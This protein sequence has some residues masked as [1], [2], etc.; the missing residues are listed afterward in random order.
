MRGPRGFL[1]A[2][3][4]GLVLVLAAIGSVNLVVDP[5]HYYRGVSAINHVFFPAYQ[6]YQNVGLARSFRYDTVVIGSS[7]TE[8]FL[9]SYIQQSWGGRAM[10]L[11]ISGSTSYEQSLIFRQAVS[12]GQVR[13]VLWGLDIPAFYGD[14]RR[15]R[16][17]QAPFPYFMYRRHAILNIEYPF[18]LSTLDLS[19]RVLKGWGESNLDE[20]DT[21]YKRFQFGERAVL[22]AWSGTCELFSRK[23]EP[24]HFELP[25][26]AID[27]MHEGVR[28]NLVPLVRR[29]PEIAFYLFFPPMA[30]LIYVP[31]DGGMLSYSLPLRRT[32]AAELGD[33][34]NVRLFDFQTVPALADDLGRYK[35][36]LHFD[37]RTSH[38]L[39]DAMR[40]GRNRV[41]RRQLLAANERLIEQANSYDYCREQGPLA[42]QQNLEK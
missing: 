20:L 19:L 5:L 39:I 30:R 27:Q 7:V 21:W 34:S 33:E 38:F 28:Q 9:P 11:S 1:A 2:F 40:D 4:T 37:L 42:Q 36:L 35:D 10:K 12:T 26:E 6:R 23:Y 16:D 14:P 31:A 18:S 24:G 13:R 17:D 22:A 29:H 3:F 41:D 32:V 15:V 25:R 8:N